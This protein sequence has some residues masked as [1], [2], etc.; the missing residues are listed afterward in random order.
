MADLITITNVLGSFQ[1]NCYTVAN[2]ETREALVIDPA[3]RGDYLINMYKTQNFKPVAI[4]LTHG[5]MD[6][7][8][9][10][11]EIRAAYPEIK[12]YAGKDEKAVLDSPQANLSAMIAGTPMTFAADE[13]VGDGDVIKLLNR[14]IKCISVPGHT[15]GGT[16]YYIAED[17]LLFSGDTLFA[18]SVGRSDFPT[19]DAEALLENIERKLFVLPEDVQVYSGHGGRTNIKREKAGNPFF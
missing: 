18:G 5:H 11:E 17:K 10:L 14:E 16:C 2:G 4:L 13:Y 7:I 19:G 6:H 15:I 12:V 1:T 3:D 9:A 8:G